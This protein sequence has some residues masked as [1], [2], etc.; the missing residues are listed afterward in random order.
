MAVTIRDIANILGLSIGAV[1]RALGG[2]PDISQETRQ[3]VFKQPK[4]WVMFQT[5]PLASYE[6]RK[7]MRLVMFYPPIHPD[8]PIRFSPNSLPDWV[9][10]QPV[11]HLT[12]LS[13]S[14]HPV[15]DR[16]ST[17]TKAG[18]RVV[19]WMDLS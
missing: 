5:A 14:P 18:S 19:R 16:K 1:S 2:Y 3:R 17:Y 7:R 8:L 10:R 6:Q 4:R 15:K 12:W 11:I 9:M 13:P